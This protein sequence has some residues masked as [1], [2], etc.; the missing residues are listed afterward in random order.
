[1]DWEQDGNVPLILVADDDRAI[2]TALKTLLERGKYRVATAAN[3]REAVDLAAELHPDLILMDVKMPV[4]DG[5]EAVQIMRN[6]E[7]SAR[8]PVIFLTA[9]AQ[10]SA[11]AARG[12]ILGAD[13]YLFKPFGV[14]E[15]LARVQR[16]IHTRRLEERLQQRTLDLEALIHLGSQLNDALTLEA[17]ADRL[18]TL[19]LH[20]LSSSA[21]SLFVIQTPDMHTLYYVYAG[22]MLQKKMVDAAS[23]VHGL[24]AERGEPVICNNRDEI[25]HFVQDRSLDWMVSMISVPL[26]HS[27]ELLGVLTVGDERE[28]R[29]TE[30]NVRQMRSIAEQAALALRNTELYTQLQRYNADLETRVEE[31]TRQ[32]MVVQ[33]QL[34]RAEKLAAIGTLAAGIAHEVNNPLQPILM[35][36]ETMLEDMEAGKPVHRD[37]VYHSYE[38]VVRISGL[39][40][41]LLDLARPERHDME[42]FDLNTL[43]EDVIALTSKQLEHTHVNIRWTPG[44]VPSILGNADQLKQVILNLVVNARDAMPNGGTLTLRTM[45]DGGSAALLVE[46]TGMG[47]AP[48][49]IEKIFDPFYT[50]KPEG[51]GLG[52]SLSH[53]IIEGHG[54]QFEVSSTLGK[55][56][57]FRIILPVTTLESG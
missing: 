14:D 46:D 13:D 11:D 1:M 26:V 30:N 27:G 51:T 56:T 36:L 29:Y 40:R 55:G 21:G 25:T 53:Q 16:K 34:M 2:R 44:K 57:Q 39:V 12:I 8:T 33:R 19:T 35:N 18:L 28:N 5:F 43:V 22:G 32:L 37:D 10:T 50:T 15:L 42:L 48:E 52:L 23:G 6:A 9:A 3:G 24:I 47:I 20:Q 7:G 38:Q 4:M 45:Y 41:R 31:R 49:M 17:L 54:G